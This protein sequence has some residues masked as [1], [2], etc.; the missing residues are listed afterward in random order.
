MA[1]ARL[2]IL[3][4]ADTVQAQQGLKQFNDTLGKTGASLTEL[5]STA[6]KAS[7]VFVQLP[8]SIDVSGKTAASAVSAFSNLQKQTAVTTAGLSKLT[9]ATN[10]ANFA[11]LNLG[12]VA[13]D[14]P[15][16][17]IGIA[18]NLNPLLESFQR[19]SRE[20]GGF[21]STMK[22]LGASLLGGG[23]I[24]LALSLVTGA[25]SF[26]A[27]RS[28]SAKTNTEELTEAQKQAKKEQEDF[29]KAINSASQSL[30]S[31]A[32]NLT[33]LKD[34]LI[35][36]SGEMR[37]LTQATINQGVAAFLF[38]KKNVEVQK[39]LNAEIQKA[40]LLRKQQQPLSDVPEFKVGPKGPNQVTL[41]DGRIITLGTP[42]ISKFNK[43][44]H[45][46]TIE[47]ERLQRMGFGLEDMFK[48]LV[49]GPK[50]IQEISIEIPETKIKTDKIEL[51]PTGRPQ[52]NLGGVASSVKL[53]IP[54]T[55]DIAAIDESVLQDIGKTFSRLGPS[56]GKVFG[57]LFTEGV[58]EA[59]KRNPFDISGA[60][61]KTAI[62]I[63]S[64]EAGFASL[65]NN[66]G[67]FVDEIFRGGN[68]FKSFGQLVM[69]TLKQLAAELIKTAFLASLLSVITGGAKSGGLGFLQAF[70]KIFGGFR[71]G[72]GPVSP[73]RSYIV[74]ENGPELFI[75]RSSGAIIPNG[76]G[77]SNIPGMMQVMQ[78]VVT[79]QISGRNIDIL[80]ARQNDYNRRN[81]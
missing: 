51:I 47:I 23:G 52:V 69:G 48:K 43:E 4:S 62:T 35:S 5:S 57:D 11:L 25:L 14:A 22:A 64:L 59:I 30:L 70:G 42:E 73:E 13:Q 15:F 12:R 60:L 39:L 72:G 21:S 66:F 49:E 58:S 44:I 79:G 71:A 53:T 24:G 3:L 38:D 9:P 67:R 61:S 18:N 2:G 16:G 36:T 20:A 27:L 54:I 77:S 8:K 10:S 34:I 6:S 45:T 68:V 56:F 31:Q 80:N 74:G 28:R 26:F 40:L 19:V 65:S 32:K 46:T 76:R 78:V 29:S 63:G 41:P 75:P 81:T 17:I 1:D 55:P 33:D 50:K 37:T 7:A